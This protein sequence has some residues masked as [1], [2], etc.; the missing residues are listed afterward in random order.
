MLKRG[1]LSVLAAAILTV[2][3][4]GDY[5]A[6]RAAAADGKAIYDGK[7]ASCH[8]ATGQG[9]PTTFPPLAGNKDVTG[10]PAKVIAAVAKGVNGAI[11]VNGKAYSGAMPAWR[12]QLTDADIA[13]VVTYIRSS[14]GNKASA[15]TEK[16]VSAVK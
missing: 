6:V 11:T 2:F 5:R 4:L 1:F 8:Q 16:Q 9:I 7:C 3:V 15:V 12:G 14:W 10:D 13:A